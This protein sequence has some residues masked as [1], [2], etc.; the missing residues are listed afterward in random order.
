M[1]VENQ[2]PYKSFTA[3]GSQNNFALGFYVDDKNHFEVKKNEQAVSRN[4]YSYYSSS[5]SIV[6]NTSPNQGDVIEIKRSTIADRATTYSTY[7]NTFRPEVLNKDLDKVWLK[8]Q[9]LGVADNLLRAYTEHLHTEQ[10]SYIDRLDTTQQNYIENQNQLIRNMITD[11]QNFVTQQDNGLT[12]SINNLRTYV[13]TQDSNLNNSL[14]NKVIQQGVS[15]QQLNNYYQHLLKGMADIASNKGWLTSL[16]IDESG[17]SQ[18]E[19]NNLQKVKSLDELRLLTPSAKGEKAFL[20]STLEDKNIGCG[21]FVATQKSGLVDDGG[22][23]IDS[24]NSLL[25]WVRIHDR[26][27]TSVDWFGADPTG[28][29][30]STPCVLAA[31]QARMKTLLSTPAQRKAATI[32]FGEGYYRVKDLP[33][34][35]GVTYKGQGRGT[36]FLFPDSGASWVFTSTP[37][38]Y[39]S[40]PIDAAKRLV[41]S[42]IE[43]MTIGWGYVSRIPSN[44]TNYSTTA[45]GIYQQASSWS[46]LKNVG[47]HGIGGHALK[48]IGV[49]DMDVDDVSIFSNGLNTSKESIYID[50]Y[51]ESSDGSNV[52]TFRRLHVEGVYKFFYIGRNSRHINFRDTKFEACKVGSEIVDTQSVNFIDLI[53][54]NSSKLGEYPF[55]TVTNSNSTYS[56]LGVT[57]V[58]PQ[59]IKMDW[60][61]ENTSR[62]RVRIIGGYAAR[63]KTLFK[64]GGLHLEG[65]F[66]TF[67]CGPQFITCSSSYIKDCFFRS[68]LPT[69]ITDGSE[70]FIIL[71]GADNTIEQNEF[72]SYNTE[73]VPFIKMD[74]NVRLRLN[75][76]QGTIPFAI[77]GAESRF[78]YNNTIAS[79]MSLYTATPNAQGYNALLNRK[80]TGLGLGSIASGQVTVATEARETITGVLGGGSFVTCRVTYNSQSYNLVLALDSLANPRNVAIIANTLPIEV[81]SGSGSEN[82]GKLWVNNWYTGTSGSDLTF[83]NHTTLPITISVV[84][85]SA[86]G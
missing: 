79:G 80:S 64:G 36:T 8:I 78:H 6:F 68:I 46:K 3:N 17:K 34:V 75:R 77:R 83:V 81:A 31:I 32:T 58:N 35:S 66:D 47:I 61:V 30:D 50:R 57:F 21:T 62:S 15:L 18:Q 49:F 59:I 16:I 4:E 12:N 56:P 11:L 86:V 48:L 9:E 39:E 44:L 45:G 53:I 40:N 73:N 25:K 7:N 23:V 26:S 1:T 54:S 29:S 42:S 19:I 41:H 20:I 38:S 67:E 74:S 24:P 5:N 70:D 55:V 51:P 84:V 22:I 33:Q 27:D 60:L 2:V 43:D 65:G 69:S 76:F 71:K 28:E 14:E 82:D 10:H 72:L 37:D 13:D 85:I 63:L 52:I